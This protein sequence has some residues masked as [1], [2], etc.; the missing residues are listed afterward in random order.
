MFEKVKFN[1]TFRN[2]QQRVLDNSTEYL[3]DGKIHIVA[4]PGSGKTVLG[5]EL[6]VRLKE[7]CLILSPTTT[8]RNQ[9]GDR[10]AE[11]FLNGKHADEYISYDL[12]DPKPLTC[13][14]YQA[15]HAAVKRLKDNEDGEDYSSFDF[16]AE[17]EKHGV[18]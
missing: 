3:N 1:G 8:I 15:L 9:W 13:V 5:L 6:I 2:Y 4:A 12:K 14:T 11:H 18:R 17:M 10:F 7:P 16:F